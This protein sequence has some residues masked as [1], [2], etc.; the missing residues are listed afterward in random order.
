[1][2]NNFEK[3]LKYVMEDEG[4]YVNHPKDPG[5]ATNFGITKKAWGDYLNK[6]V[7]DD[8]IKNLKKPVASAF[9]KK[10][11][12]DVCKCDLLPTGIDYCVFD[13]AVNSGP[14]KA[15][16]ILQNS[17]GVV[18][19][20][21]VGNKTILAA[22]NNKDKSGIITVIC[23]K[24]LTFLKSLVSYHVFGNGWLSRIKKVQSKSMEMV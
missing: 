9:Y 23:S 24:R 5:G 11:Y 10:K 3:S 12:W 1:M 4:G 18:C 7:T 17:L 8:D 13:F 2:K 15:I 22:Q 19:D 14:T 21:I 6:I 20:G 16:K